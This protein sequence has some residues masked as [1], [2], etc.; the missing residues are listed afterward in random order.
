MSWF[1]KTPVVE[2]EPPE[3]DIDRLAKCEAECI[4]ADAA[5]NQACANLRGYNIE[6]EQNRFMFTNKH[7]DS[8]VQTMCADMERK[9]FERK[10]RETL[11]RRNE[12]LSARA[13]LL[14]KLGL[15]K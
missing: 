2:V 7:G 12:A 11:D 10:L 3:T 1:S 5:W 14:L 13:T 6:H 4:F 8:Y 15:I 9:C